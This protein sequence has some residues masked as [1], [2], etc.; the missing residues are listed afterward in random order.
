MPIEKERII[1]EVDAEVVYENREWIASLEYVLE[2]QGPERVRALLRMLQ[3]RAQEH[4]VAF[5]FAANT[6][7]INTITVERQPAYPGSREIERR[8]KSIIRWNAMAMVVRANR[9]SAG[10]G[11][12][13]STYASS[14]TLYEVGFNHF[15]RAKS[16]DHPGDIVYFQGHAAPGIYARAFLEGRI[17]QIQLENFRR[18]LRPAGGLSSY[19]HPFLMPEFWQFPT[20]SMG[21]SPLM[22][23]YQARFNR[24]LQDRGLKASDDQK[25]WAFLGDGE[26]DE[27]ESL[28][29][30]T[31]A[32]R[33]AL[34]NLIFVVNCNLQRLDGPVRGNGKIIQE[35][36]AAFRG[37]GWNVIKVIWGGDWDPLL[38]QDREG[39]LVKRM[40]EVPDGQYQMYS[41][42]GGA[43]IRKDFFGRYP[44]LEQMVQNYSD[45]QLFKL[46]RG[47]HDPQK[48][49]AAY[50]AAVSHKGAP[51]VILAKTI[52]GYGLGEAG[53]GRNVTHQQKKLNDDELRQFRSRFGIP[54][55]DSAIAKMPF[56]RPA[57]DSEE[58]KYLHERRRRLGGYL[59]ARSWSVPASR[60]PGEALY[61]EFME[62]SGERETATTMVMVHL[63]SK[64]LKDKKMGPSIVP[65][66]PDEAR[67]FGME[68]LFR[69]VGIYSHVGQLY[70][71]VD[72]ES[73]LY[74]KEATDGQ[75]LEEGITEAGSMASFIAAGTAYS[76]HGINMIP[77]FFFYS[78]FGFQRIG[79]LIWAAGDAQARGFLLGATAG[80]T[81]LA[82]EGLQ[83]QD[84]HSHILAYPNPGIQAY[85]PAFAYEVAVIVREGLRRMLEA[86]DNII[87]YI[88][89]MNEFYKMP[90]K[91]R[92]VDQG[93]LNG[94]YKFR[95]SAGGKTKS[96]VHL[97]GSGTIMN[98]ALKAQEM[99]SDQ[100]GIA[101][102]VW[103]VTSYKNLYW[104]AVKTQRWNLR[105]PDQTPRRTFIQQQMADE[106]GIFVAA[107]DY[108]KALPATIAPWVPGPL[109]LLGT[110]G[111]G[112]S[113]ARA[114][115][116][117]Y[118][119]VDARH[120]AFAA[121]S[122]LAQN[123]KI[124][125]SV[126]KKAMKSLQIDPGKAAALLA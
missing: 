54:I 19:P 11:G 72:K 27:P 28:G 33:E 53:E 17:S 61:A 35:L 76:T 32:S 20:V 40:E 7:Y 13:I 124:A 104:D 47:G 91:P 108:L 52:K 67:T 96:K 92:G 70:E 66:V 15:F 34:D 82:G 90:A 120:I 126:V 121:L 51:T 74:Y 18:E 97:L 117:D 62:G 37:A 112:R 22:A 69:T 39:L 101:T 42:A 98:E 14:A 114:D 88:T 107:S 12:H 80:R 43:Y 10:I 113:D 125:V 85:D 123:K 49:Y 73:L 118:F 109:T 59:P 36:E 9:E 6:P 23:I 86:G 63:L 44:E 105:H 115:L 3:T 64:L 46:R 78:I 31:L 89:I 58:M 29:A 55:P 84:G 87:Y 116:R 2:N 56:Y 4:G 30:I 38:T 68:S 122:G 26:L 111:Y 95:S 103:S 81:T 57:D 24:Y 48:V 83:H 119:E 100:Y 16:A 21:L 8:I 93:I 106:S 79:D 102:D 5:P 25:V 71:P 50:Q 41:V 110:D 77:F 75:I 94:M 60:P 1:G 65:I 99:L 45:D